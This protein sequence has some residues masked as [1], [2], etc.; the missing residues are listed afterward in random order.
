[1]PLEARPTSGRRGSSHRCDATSSPRGAPSP[2]RKLDGHWRSVEAAEGLWVE[3]DDAVH[4]ARE[5]R[6][7][8]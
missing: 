1:T 4:L 2:Q 5:Q 7:L 8:W 6:F 3:R